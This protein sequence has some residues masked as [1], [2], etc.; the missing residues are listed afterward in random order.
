MLM[1]DLAASLAAPGTRGA[2][3]RNTPSGVLD[4]GSFD[5]AAVRALY[6][7]LADGH[8]YLDGAAGTQVPASVIEAITAAYRAGIGNLGGAFPASGRS[9]EIVAGARAAVADLVGGTPGGVVFG[10]SA[11]ALAYQISDAL[12]RVWT[13]GDEIVVSR[14]DHD[15][16]VR[17]WIQAA[18]RA[19]VTVKW[20]EADLVTGELPAAQYAELIGPRTP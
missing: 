13:P 10:P 15:S 4:P 6:P 9:E 19:G 3:R 1:P 14:L 20:A 8:A 12:S 17:P 11:T 16:N 5:V 2:D 7:A 18:G